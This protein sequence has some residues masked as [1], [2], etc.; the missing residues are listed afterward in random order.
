MKARSACWCC[1]I[2]AATEQR[3]SR[4]DPRTHSRFHSD[5][6]HQLL[7]QGFLAEAEGEFQE[8]ISLNP[9]NA[10]AHAGLATVFEETNN[11]SGARA[12]AEA[13]L[14]SAPVCRT[15]SNPRPARF[16]RQ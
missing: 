9:A 8:A 12:E 3:L 4:T 14:Q 10:D 13:A 1:K 5:R 6:G 11:F 16:A 2:D 15:F 7:G